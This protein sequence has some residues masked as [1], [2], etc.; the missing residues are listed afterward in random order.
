[1]PSEL[2]EKNEKFRFKGI[3]TTE[4]AKANNNTSNKR[5]FIGIGK[6]P[7]ESEAFGN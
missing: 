2:T 4:A 5:F 3:P 1:M 7:L 6:S